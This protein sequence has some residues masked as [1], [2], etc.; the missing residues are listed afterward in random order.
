MQKTFPIQQSVVYSELLLLNVCA[1]W[2]P[3]F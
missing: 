1:S 2:M 3:P